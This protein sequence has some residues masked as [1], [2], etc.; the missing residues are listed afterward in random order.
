MQYKLSEQDIAVIEREINRKGS[1]KIEVSIKN[2]ELAVYR[3]E[4]KRIEPDN[5]TR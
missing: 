1:P 4:S 3:I 2:E 5:E